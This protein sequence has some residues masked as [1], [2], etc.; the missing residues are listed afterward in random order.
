MKFNQTTFIGIVVVLFIIAIIFLFGLSSSKKKFEVLPKLNN[1]QIMDLI[2]QKDDVQLVSSPAKWGKRNPFVSPVS[3][4]TSDHTIVLAGVFWGSSKPS[5]IFNTFTQVDGQN[6]PQSVVAGVGEKVNDL[7]VKEIKSDGVVLSDS[8]GQAMVFFMKEAFKVP[9]PLAEEDDED[10]PQS[11]GNM[12]Q[13]S[14]PT[15]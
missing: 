5:A 3:N 9:D 7:T 6:I 8:Q 15:Q 12:Q 10:D 1:K 14:I 4:A 2:E 11:T 13:T